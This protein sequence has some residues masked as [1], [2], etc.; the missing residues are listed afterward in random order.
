MTDY[1]PICGATVKVVTSDEGTSYYE[2][3]KY[4][5]EGPERRKPCDMSSWH[6]V[7]MQDGSTAAYT[8]DRAM[9]RMHPYVEQLRKPTPNSPT[10]K[11]TS[12]SQAGVPS[13]RIPNAKWWAPMP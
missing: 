10:K 8:P 5:V 11:T 12:A 7:T 13:C 9:A 6:R 2:P 1:C 3:I 4:G